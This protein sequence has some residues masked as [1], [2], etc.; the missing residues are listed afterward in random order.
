[1]MDVSLPDEITSNSLNSEVLIIPAM[2]PPVLNVPAANS[3]TARAPYI[4]RAIQV[5]SSSMSDHHEPVRQI[6]RSTEVSGSFWTLSSADSIAYANRVAYNQCC[7]ARLVDNST[8]IACEVQGL[9]FV[10]VSDN[11][12]AGLKTLGIGTYGLTAT[13]VF[14]RLQHDEPSTRTVAHTN[15]LRG[16]VNDVLYQ[17]LPNPDD[18]MDLVEDEARL[19]ETLIRVLRSPETMLKVTGPN[20]IH[21]PTVKEKID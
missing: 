5:P 1:M 12:V 3:P 16:S 4:P 11:I 19:F 9:C 10:I 14:V 17:E 21:I 13:Y 20:I 8:T 15:A 6:Q 2:Y 18:L 7:R